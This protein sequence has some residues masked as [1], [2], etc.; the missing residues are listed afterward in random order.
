MARRARY[1]HDM[2]GTHVHSAARVTGTTLPRQPQTL[3][4]TNRVH[5]DHERAER[6]PAAFALIHHAAEELI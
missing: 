6:N 5:V 1:D 4:H 3:H 2:A